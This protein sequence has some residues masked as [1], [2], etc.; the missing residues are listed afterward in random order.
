MKLVYKSNFKG[1]DQLPLGELPPDAVKFKE[2]ESMETL[3]VK[4]I[5]FSIPALPLIA[6][7]I[8]GS[9]FLHGTF[10]FEFVLLPF[11]AGIGIS[12]LSLLPH[13]LLHAICFGKGAVVELYIALTHGM[14]FVVST[15]PITKMRFIFLSLLPNLLLGWLPLIIWAVL[16][17]VEMYSTILFTCSIINILGGGGDY[18]NTYNALRQMPKGSMQ[19]LSGFNSYWFMP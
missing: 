7:I 19:Q 11:A 1:M 5:L 14:L 16:P 12:I 3:T 18:M 9:R 6:L 15:H 2:P 8:M 17:Y 13:E 4:V 10:N